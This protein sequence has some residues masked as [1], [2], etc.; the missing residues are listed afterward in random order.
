VTY[1]FTDAPPRDGDSVGLDL[2]GR[3]MLV[4]AE[5]FKALVKKIGDTYG[6]DVE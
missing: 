2:A 1:G 3:A 4:P 5:K 6:I